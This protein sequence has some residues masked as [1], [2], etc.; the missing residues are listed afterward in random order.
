MA[1]Y[2]TFQQIWFMYLLAAIGLYYVV[3][4]LSKYWIS[5]ERKNYFRMVS[6]VI[7]FTP[8][9]HS[10]YGTKALAPAF[11]VMFGE[12]FTSGVKA[13]MTGLVPLLLG[14]FIGA[15]ALAAQA[16]IRVKRAQKVES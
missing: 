9:S 3:V 16:F 5:E 1:Y 8:A 14:L 13:A 2:D 15:L 7:L 11:I 10:I 12:L 6:A 4:K